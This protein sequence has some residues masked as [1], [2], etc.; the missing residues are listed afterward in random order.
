MQCTNN[1]KQLCLACHNYHDTLKSFPPGC[2]DDAELIETWGWGV[3]ILPFIEQQPLYNNLGVTNR[4]LYHVLMDPTD[5]HL[6]QTP[7]AEFRCPSDRTEELLDKSSRHF[8]G[9][10]NNAGGK[11]EMSTSNYIACQ[12]FYDKPGLYKNNGVFYNNS[13]IRLD[14]DIPDG[15][16]HTFAIG[17]RDYRCSAGHWAGVR[18]PPGPCHWGVYHSRGRVSKQLNSPETSWPRPSGW[19]ACNSCGEGFSSPHPGGANFAFCDGTV[20]FISENIEF[21][22]AGLTQSNLTS[23]TKYDPLLLGLYQRL[24]IRDDG[25]PASLD[26]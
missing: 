24:G 13:H 14:R 21:S 2:I 8:F 10:G 15:T 20:H 26:D 9:R 12:G 17:E 3:F 6:L 1:L 4:K 25:Q 16:S 23:G 22:N 5:Q 7:L 18:N 11:I 19:N